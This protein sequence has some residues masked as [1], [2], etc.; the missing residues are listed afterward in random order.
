M[1]RYEQLQCSWNSVSNCH[2]HLLQVKPSVFWDYAKAVGL[3]T[4]V[5]ICFLYAGQSS[6]AIGANVWLS[7][8]TNDAVVDGKQNNTYL[9]LGVYAALGILQGEPVGV[10]RRGSPISSSLLALRLPKPYSCLRVSLTLQAIP[11]IRI[12]PFIPTPSTR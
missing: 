12:C 4:T 2:D 11:C 10:P 7:D 6:A 5:A 1:N 8:W 9:R 3:C